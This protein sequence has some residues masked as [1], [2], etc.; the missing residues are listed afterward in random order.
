MIIMEVICKTH[1][2]PRARVNK[3]KIY[4]LEL[5]VPRR[6]DTHTRTA[7]LNTSAEGFMITGAPSKHTT[8]QVELFRFR[9]IKNAYTRVYTV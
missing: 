8:D 4:G 2:P 7:A 9:A 5:S 3:N 1:S 6:I